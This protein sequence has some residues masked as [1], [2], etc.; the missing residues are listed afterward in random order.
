MSSEHSVGRLGWPLMESEYLPHSPPP[1][2]LVLET[3]YLHEGSEES[4]CCL[5]Y[6]MHAC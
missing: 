2:P 6:Y 4:I 1:S 5:R 3:N